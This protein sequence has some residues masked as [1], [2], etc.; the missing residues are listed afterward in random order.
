MKHA[1]SHGKLICLAFVL[2]ALCQSAAAQ[3]PGP[4]AT[5][6]LFELDLELGLEYSDNRARTSPRGASETALVP[7]AILDV[8]RSGDRMTLR[9]AGHAEQRVP[10]HGPFGND[11]F[12]NLGARLNWH[13]VEER[14]DWVVENVASGSPVD[15]SGQ[16][17]PE[18]RQQTNVFSTGPRWVLR[19]AAAWSGLFDARYIHSYAE[20]SDAFNSD[21]LALAARAVR[22]LRGGRQI[23]AGVEASEVR[24]RQDEFSAADYQ[25]LDL[26]GRYRS[27]RNDFD[28]DLAGGRTRI[29]LDRGI[30]LEDNLLRARLIWNV[31]HRHT[32]VASAG[33]ELSDSV[34]Q[35][36]AGIDQIDLPILFNQRFRTDA[37]FRTGNEIYVLDSIALGWRSR[38]GT[39]DGSVHVAWRDYQFELE[40]LLDVEEH[41]AAVGLTWR[42]AATMALEGGLGLERRRFRIEDQR[43]TDL[44]ASLFLTRQLNPR[45]SGRVGAMRHQRDSNIIGESSRGNVVA[46]YLTYHAGR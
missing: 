21:R 42:M 28:L 41:G 29:D 16:I 30:R 22:R 37:E 4:I 27:T 35:L 25:R 15:L 31:D 1:M 5:P 7:R 14:L 33:H 3:D 10:L 19:P 38:I 46:V 44:W 34:R 9:A 13:L 18:N 12:A 26:V 23:S 6:E 43:D 32:L 24:Y 2:A 45:W 40:P 11:F 8:Y 39:L 36:A 17:T 20:D